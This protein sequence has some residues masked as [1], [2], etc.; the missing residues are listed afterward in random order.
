MSL[1]SA[2]LANALEETPDPILTSKAMI[3][4]AKWVIEKRKTYNN[5]N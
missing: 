1:A 4:S 3:E 5:P 2:P